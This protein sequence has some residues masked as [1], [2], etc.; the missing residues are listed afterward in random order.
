[1]SSKGKLPQLVLDL[2]F[3]FGADALRDR[4]DQN[5]GVRIEPFFLRLNHSV[6]DRL[7]GTYRESIRH[8]TYGRRCPALASMARALGYPD[9][10]PDFD[11]R[12][13]RCD[14]LHRLAAMAHGQEEAPA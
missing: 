13:R 6:T 14:D 8:L 9:L 3:D 10:H 12:R 2:H 5:V 7:R 1:M 11:R 4:V